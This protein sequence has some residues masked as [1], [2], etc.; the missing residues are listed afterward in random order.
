MVV[1]TKV[2]LKR[3]DRIME[4]RFNQPIRS[5]QVK[6]MAEAICHGI[7][8]SSRQAKEEKPENSVQHLK[9]KIAAWEKLISDWYLSNDVDEEEAIR[10]GKEMRQLSA[11][12]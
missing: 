3:A 8:D 7:N 1:D 4:K 6:I 9:A 11:V 10:V 2:V 12:E 5:R